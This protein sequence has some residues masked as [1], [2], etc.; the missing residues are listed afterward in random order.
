ME[1]IHRA[2]QPPALR[3]TP[4][5]LNDRHRSCISYFLQL[6]PNAARAI[7]DLGKMPTRPGKSSR[8]GSFREGD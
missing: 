5:I 7:G 8:D 6:P 1:T 3:L 4:N 2:R